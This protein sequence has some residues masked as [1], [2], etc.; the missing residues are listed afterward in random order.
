MAL[1]CCFKILTLDDNLSILDFQANMN[2]LLSAAKYNPS[3]ETDISLALS[4]LVI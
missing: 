2:L 3:I 4:E 1:S